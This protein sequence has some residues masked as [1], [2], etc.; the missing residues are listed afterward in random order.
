MRVRVRNQRYQSA[1]SFVKRYQPIYIDVEHDV[2][3]THHKI[4]GQFVFDKIQSAGGTHTFVFH[5]VFYRNAEFRAVSEIV[6]YNLVQMSDGNVNLVYTVLFK[7]FYCA[8][9]YGFPQH[10]CHRFGYFVFRYFRQTRS[11]P[12]RNYNAYHYL[13]TQ[14]LTPILEKLTG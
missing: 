9:Q 2:S 3:R 12:A 1:F 6:L 5:H 10:F 4:V 7:I 11:A 8:F 13:I 14:L